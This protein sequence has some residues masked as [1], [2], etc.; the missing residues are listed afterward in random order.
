MEVAL[1]NDKNISPSQFFG[2]LCLFVQRQPCN[3]SAVDGLARFHFHMFLTGCMYDEP[4][5]SY[6]RSEFF[7]KE[8]DFF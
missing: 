3:N 5:V 4:K 6:G 7:S 8:L 1:K 2:Q